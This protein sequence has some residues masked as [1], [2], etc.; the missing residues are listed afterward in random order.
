MF[1]HFTYY[2]PI[3]HL[4]TIKIATSLTPS[5]STK[6]NS[7]PR[8]AGQFT[9]LIRLIKVTQ[10]GDQINTQLNNSNQGMTVFVPTDNAFY[11]LK[12]G[13]INSLSVQQ[14][15]QLVQFHVLA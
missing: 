2:H 6:H 9:T 12:S 10:V 4:N 15:I 13:T 11:G 8:K 1:T 14:Q 7:N 5:G 3:F